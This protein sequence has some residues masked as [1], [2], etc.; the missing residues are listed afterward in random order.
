MLLGTDTGATYNATWFD[1]RTGE[2]TEAESGLKNDGRML[3]LPD[4]PDVSDWILIVR[5]AQGSR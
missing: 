2:S 3:A 5:K 4:R 1:P